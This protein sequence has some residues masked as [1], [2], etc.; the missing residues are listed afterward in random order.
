MT[1][2]RESAQEIVCFQPILRRTGA[3]L[4]PY[5]ETAYYSNARDGSIP[6]WRLARCPAGSHGRDHLGAQR[7]SRRICLRFGRGA[8]LARRRN[9]AANDSARIW[10]AAKAETDIAYL[11][12]KR[13]RADARVR[14]ALVCRWRELIPGNSPAAVELQ[15][16]GDHPRWRNIKLSSQASPSSNWLSSRTWVAEALAPRSRVCTYLDSLPRFSRTSKRTAQ[17]RVLAP[18]SLLTSVREVERFPPGSLWALWWRQIRPFGLLASCESR[19]PGWPK[20]ARKRRRQIGG[21]WSR[22][23]WRR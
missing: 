17:P 15:S 8:G 11:W 2:G 6:Q 3:R 12:R 1:F 14:L 13:H 9:R 5:E 23:L 4:I 18:G 22:S 19:L 16:S 10:P 7:L 20:N 21:W